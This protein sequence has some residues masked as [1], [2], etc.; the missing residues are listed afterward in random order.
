MRSAIVHPLT[1]LDLVLNSAGC[2]VLDGERLTADDL[3]T[4]AGRIAVGLERRGVGPGSG[5]VVVD[6]A[7]GRDV[8]AVLLGTWWLGAHATILPRS[9]TASRLSAASR[10][11]GASV[12][13][14][15][16]ALGGGAVP[17][18]DLVAPTSAT[19][20]KYPG[21]NGSDIALDI[22]TSG[23]TG[24]PKFVSFTHEALAVNVA[25]IARRL[26][27]GPADRLY[28]PLPVSVAG[29]V[30]MVLLPGLLAGATTCIGRLEGSEV[31]HASRDI[32]ELAPTFVYGV[33]YVFDIV[34]RLGRAVDHK[35][36]RWLVCSSAP[37]PQGTFDRV[38]A[39]FGV[40]PRS[41]YCLAEAGTVTLNTGT[42]D[43][44]LRT[45][46]G[47][48]LDHVTVELD[49][50]A[51]GRRRVVVGGR[52]C[53]LG[54]RRAGRIERFADGRVVTSD[55]GS[56]EGGV[57]RLRGRTDTIIQVAAQNVDITEV[58]DAMASCPGIKDYAVVA[59]HDHALGQ[60]PVLLVA[61]DGCRATVEQILDF[62]RTVLP[63]VAVP[64]S[65]RFVDRI[66]RSAAGKPT[67]PYFDG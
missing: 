38:S 41:S 10:E 32:R 22:A 46:V 34:S 42:D 55:Y 67:L 63:A 39:Y 64:R 57:L 51:A 49:A 52:S 21:C 23:T 19:T 3:A 31:R 60:V 65:V 36:L 25:D 9:T 44:E 30:G 27:L 58:H 45:S 43:D 8:L 5:V 15:A 18:G 62:C 13:V 48:P 35:D 17:F 29:V 1:L 66:A 12:V 7:S 53:G 33:P 11:T 16:S 4:T 2:V 54:Y 14:S 24:R 61:K 40:P 50:L 28:S 56:L 47:V 37:L 20:G 6:N 26:G 59:E